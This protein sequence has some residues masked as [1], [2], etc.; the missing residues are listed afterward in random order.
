MALSNITVKGVTPDLSILGNYQR[1]SYEDNLTSFQ[2]DNIFVSTTLIPAQMNFEFR[3][4]QLSGFR[5]Y[6]TTTDT[7]SFGSLALQSFVNAEPDGTDIMIFGQDGSINFIAPI[8]ISSLS[9]GHNLDMNDY[10]IINLADPEDP[11]DG[12]TKA[13]VD[14]KTITLTGAVT[15]TGVLGTIATTLTAITVSQISNFD[16]SVKAYRLDQ[17]AAPITSVSFGSQKITNLLTPTL[18]TDA[19]TKGY[20][21]SAVGSGSITLTGAVTGT[22][23]GTISTT[24]TNINTSQISNFD[25]SVKAYRLDQFAAPITSVSFGS[26]KITNLLTPTLTTDAAT[27][28]YVDSAVGS[29]SITLT[30]AVTGTGTGTISTTLTNINTSQISNFDTAVKAYR[31]D[32]FASPTTSVSMGSQKITNL[33][34][35][36]LT[37]DAATKAYVDSNTSNNTSI[38]ESYFSNFSQY[39][40]N[41]FTTQ[42]LTANTWTKI[43][44]GTIQFGIALNNINSN[45]GQSLF[46]TVG[47]INR[48]IKLANTPIGN[49]WYKA[50]ADAVIRS[51]SGTNHNISLQI[52]K[53]GILSS[54]AP[55]SFSNRVIQNNIDQ[56]YQIKTTYFQLFP[57][58][59]IEVFVLSTVATTI[60]TSSLVCNLLNVG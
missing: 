23:T 20:V 50:E 4:N 59:Y 29:G 21:D 28:G 55:Y 26:Q 19:A 1:F 56:G 9:V 8:T 49:N 10:R 44:N 60:T 43:T 27:K 12:A 40:V 33:A 58:D 6:H 25:A 14:G 24:L 2:L 37:T 15:G 54:V 7:D 39:F 47:N 13:Y 22:G 36:T 57:N 51:S 31:L 3:N 35:P 18:T 52:V 16:A 17:F 38:T 42:T 48:I 32:Q 30:G 5:W 34:T 46:Q 45:T 53:N 11:Q 41:N